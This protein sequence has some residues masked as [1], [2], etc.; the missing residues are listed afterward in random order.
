M[1]KVTNI[2]HPDLYSDISETVEYYLK[3]G[4]DV[5]AYRFKESLY[6]KMTLIKENPMTGSKYE[7]DEIN[8]ENIRR[9]SV[10]NRSN[11]RES[12]FHH[13]KPSAD[14]SFTLAIFTHW[15]HPED[16]I[17]ETIYNRKDELEITSNA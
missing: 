7:S 3:N 8:V 9:Q 16:T 15:Q 4:A 10:Q 1:S 17:L 6:T 5:Y 12:L 2:V 11:N 13:Y 14:N